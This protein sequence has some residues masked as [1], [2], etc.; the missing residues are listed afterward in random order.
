MSPNNSFPQY[1]SGL[2]CGRNYT[3]LICRVG[4]NF[5]F[6]FMIL[7][8][9]FKFKWITFSKN[10]FTTRAWLS[11][12]IRLYTFSVYK[13]VN[14]QNRR[15]LLMFKPGQTEDIRLIFDNIEGPLIRFAYFVTECFCNYHNCCA[16]YVCLCIW[17][18]A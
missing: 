9:Y 18:W 6:R 3:C 16:K 15:K 1:V 2:P 14:T 11:H 12:T 10:P 17:L 13:S 8:V 7:S 5:D 4:F